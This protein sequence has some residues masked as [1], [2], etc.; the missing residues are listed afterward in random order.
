MTRANG[1]R[2]EES[3]ASTPSRL[4]GNI[5]YALYPAIMNTERETDGAVPEK[6]EQQYEYSHDL[7]SLLTL[8]VSLR[9]FNRRLALHSFSDARRAPADSSP[10]FDYCS[11][12]EYYSSRNLY[13]SSLRTRYLFNISHLPTRSFSAQPDFSTSDTFIS[14][15]Q[16][17]SST[18]FTRSL[19][20]K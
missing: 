19:K 3:R 10:W 7:S 1:T 9:C 13:L 14:V 15:G 16:G 20:A 6:S 5:G 11:D 17:Y 4:I 2:N 8:G 18:K 12:K